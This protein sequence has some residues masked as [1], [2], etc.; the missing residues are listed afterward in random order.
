[1]QLQHL[2]PGLDI[3]CK[4]DDTLTLTKQTVNVL[5]WAKIGSMNV[6]A[7]S[8]ASAPSGATCLHDST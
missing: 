7:V 3:V 2:W 1:M 8:S 4:R 6:I 5:T